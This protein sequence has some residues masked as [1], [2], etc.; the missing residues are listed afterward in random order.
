M[1]LTHT[2]IFFIWPATH[3]LVYMTSNPLIIYVT[4]VASS[5][6]LAVLIDKTR[7]VLKINKLV[8]NLRNIL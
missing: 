2:F 1:F 7:G 4:G 6:V 8:F 5:L 3:N